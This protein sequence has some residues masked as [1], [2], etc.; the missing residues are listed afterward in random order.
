MTWLAEI[1]EA[2]ENFR[3]NVDMDILPVQRQAC[4]YAVVT[5]MDP[6]V[7]LAAV[8]IQPFGA[9]GALNSQV[10]VIRTLG[11]IADD[12]SLVVGIHLAGFKEIAVVMHTDCGGSLAYTMIDP[13]VQN[14]RTSLAPA[15]WTLFKEQIGDPL[16]ERLREWLHAFQNP[17]QAVRK[18]VDAINAYPFAP[19]SLIV[20]GLVYD[21]TSGAI[22]VVV[23]GY[24]T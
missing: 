24:A 23:D 16:R 8:G 13:L 1:R 22:D 7:N 21:L 10:R 9:D 4:P 19:A 20:H 11:G 12:R 2:N 15:Q 18:E 17:H 5:C 3:K 14:M 6:R